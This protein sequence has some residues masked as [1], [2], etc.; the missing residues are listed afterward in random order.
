LEEIGENNNDKH[1]AMQ[2]RPMGGVVAEP[3]GN[4]QNKGKTC[5]TPV[6]CMQYEIEDNMSTRK[7]GAFNEKEKR[8]ENLEENWHEQFREEPE[9][10]RGGVFKKGLNSMMM[11]EEGEKLGGTKRWTV[12]KWK[13]HAREGGGSRDSPMDLTGVG[14]KKKKNNKGG[15]GKEGT[16]KRKKMEQEEDFNILEA[17]IQQPCHV[18]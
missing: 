16:E 15:R 12:K 6:A 3:V 4:M 2:E 9:T 18:Q 13:R 1:V 8:G 11:D 10:I 7:E 14:K 17:A 5:V